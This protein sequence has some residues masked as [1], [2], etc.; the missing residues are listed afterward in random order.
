MTISD[1]SKKDR[2]GL[3][4]LLLVG[5]LVSGMV[6]VFVAGDPYQDDDIVHYLYS[7]YVF[8]HAWLFID[9]WGRPVTTI[10]Y[11]LPAQFGLVTARLF[12]AM[13][14][15]VVGLITCWVAR[16]QTDSRAE[17]ATMFLFVQPFYF[18]AS[19]GIL[20][21]LPFA[22]LLSVALLLLLQKRFLLSCLVVSLLPAAR[23]EGYFIVLFWLFP[24]VHGIEKEESGLVY[25]WGS[26]LSL[27][28]GALLWN[29]LGYLQT[30]DPL[31]LIHAFPYSSGSLGYYGTGTWYH[32]V[33]RLPFITGPVALPFFLLGFVRLVRNRQFFFPALFFYIFL[34]HSVLWYYG[35]M[36][37]AGYERYFVSI[38]PATAII[39][40]KGWRSFLVGIRKW[41]EV[42]V[43]YP[44]SYLSF[45]HLK[46]GL[47]TLFVLL[48]VLVG[49]RVVTWFN[50]TERYA[51]HQVYQNIADWYD[52]KKA[53]ESI[54][55]VYCSKSYFFFAIGEDKLQHPSVTRSGLREAKPGALYLWNS[56]YS[57]QRNNITRRYVKS[58]GFRQVRTFHANRGPK[59]KPGYHVIVFRKQ[60]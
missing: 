42:D 23:P 28:A 14:G 59:Y 57:A 19:T 39:G 1:E 25:K 40:M 13:L 35:F 18:I 47:L 48:S 46:D 58:I 20:T 11:A 22:L 31:W 12:S 2:Y 4:Y 52:E 49:L 10:L 15:T 54:P 45:Q 51:D 17:L 7:R 21:E 56:H 32:Y 37:S 26:I 33:E 41:K 9:Q 30:G 24:A 16:E 8:D 53:E 6:F 36:K 34:L 29:T 55:E 3:L 50:P 38:A 5:F 43:L 27:G 60:E 44:F